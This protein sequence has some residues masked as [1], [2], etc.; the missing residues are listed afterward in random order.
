MKNFDIAKIF[1]EIADMLDI[2][3]VQWE[4][5]AYRKGAQTLENLS[6]DI[7]EVYE[8]GGIKELKKI[9]SIGD[10]LAKKIESYIKTGK[11]QKYEDLKKSFPEHF[12]ELI[13]IQGMGPKKALLLRE[14]LGIKT[15]K[16]LEKAIKQ[17]KLA[18]LKNLGEKTEKNIDNLV[19]LTQTVFSLF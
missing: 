9:Q 5:R 7:E 17:H 14:K 6:K 2:K 18:N 10:A 13:Q 3:G 1:Y 4:P 16:D 11:I 8:K 19:F 12:N 15:V